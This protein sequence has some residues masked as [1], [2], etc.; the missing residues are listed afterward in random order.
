MAPKTGGPSG[1]FSRGSFFFFIL[2]AP[3]GIA[4]IVAI[5]LA[6]QYKQFKAVVSPAAEVSTFTLD[7][8]SHARVDT[9]FLNFHA[10]VAKDAG[11][12]SLWLDVD[13]LNALLASSSVATVQGMRFKVT[14]HDTLLI[15]KSTQPVQSMQGQL[16]WLFKKMAPT[17]Y[18]NATLEG[19]PELSEGRLMFS[20]K[21][22][23]L[24]GQKVPSIA[25]QKRGGMSPADFMEHKE[26]YNEFLQSV[27]SVALIHGRVL[28][29]RKS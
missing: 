15:V 20:P 4:F 5:I 23:Y 14:E 17:G 9:L 22:G 3:A 16:A 7:S 6:T 10:F 26:F 8:V 11:H 2:L 27:K 29:V 24:N 18:L 19:T 28:F 25:L 12:D 13:D 1:G 21:N